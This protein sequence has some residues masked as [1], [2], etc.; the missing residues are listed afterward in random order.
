MFL[1]YD[2]IDHKN[3]LWKSYSVH[4][5]CNVGKTAEKI[6]CWK[7]KK[8]FAQSHK[9]LVETLWIKIDFSLK[10]PLDN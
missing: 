1:T 5:K 4:R 8:C 2:L 7:S 3:F 6:F 10:F 9:T